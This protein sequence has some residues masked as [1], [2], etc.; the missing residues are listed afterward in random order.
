MATIETIVRPVAVKTLSLDKLPTRRSSGSV[1]SSAGVLHSES[2]RSLVDVFLIGPE[3]AAVNGLFATETIQNLG[4]YS[5]VFL[6][7]PNGSG[8]SSLAYSL[9]A[10]YCRAFSKAEPVFTTG[11]DFA[12]AYAAAVHADDMDRFRQRFRGLGILVIDGLHEL[13]PK[14]SAQIELSMTIDA[15][16]QLRSPVVI[17]AMSLPPT[18]RGIRSS[19]V[20]R[21]IR[22]LSVGIEYPGK[23][24]RRKLLQ[25]F[26]KAL[27]TR[28]NDHELDQL[29]SRLPDPTSAVELYSVLMNWLH[30]ERVERSIS[31]EAIQH[32]LSQIIEAKRV[33]ATPTIPEIAK[34]VAKEC[35]LKLT[36]LRG[37]T[38]RS[39]VV[40]ARSLAM[41]L[42]RK[43]T[44]LSFQQIGAYFGNRDHTTVLHACKKMETELFNDIELSRI[45]SEIARQLNLK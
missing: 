43:W 17:T 7:G 4:D 27:D 20:S 13:A 28:L 24:V 12:R 18:I 34:R 10:R 8:K 25:L 11:G 16:E 6:Y 41:S 2:P 37:A 30:Q 40:R 35:R 26:S 31:P 19:L 5:P 21:C 29:S 44:E 3:N 9:A 36:D 39:Q 1:Q 15:L 22:G 14:E 33:L 42:A 45:A 23:A 32:T 38:R